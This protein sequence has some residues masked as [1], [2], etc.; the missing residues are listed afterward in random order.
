MKVSIIIV[1]YTGS[2]LPSPSGSTDNEN[3]KLTDTGEPVKRSLIL[4]IAVGCGIAAFCFIIIGIVVGWWCGSRNSKKSNTTQGNKPY[5][6]MA[7]S[8]G[9]GK[10][11]WVPPSDEHYAI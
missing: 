8:A 1:Y 5:K 2:G 3:E 6:G 11:L 7:L 4:P 10:D 9:S